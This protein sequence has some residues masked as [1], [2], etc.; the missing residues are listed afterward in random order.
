MAVSPRL[1]RPIGIIFLTIALLNILFV[2]YPFADTVVV[3]RFCPG[4]WIFLIFVGIAIFAL[5]PIIF[6]SAFAVYWLRRKKLKQQASQMM[7]PSA[8]CA[9]DV[10]LK[11][12]GIG[13]GIST[14]ILFSIIALI[15]TILVASYHINGVP[16]RNAAQFGLVYR[17]NV[18]IARDINLVP[19]IQATTLNDVVFAQ[20]LVHCQ[21]RLYQMD[22]LQRLAYGTLSVY[23]GEA[24]VQSDIYFRTLNFNQSAW[25]TWNVLDPN[26]Q[27]ALQAYSDGVNHY[28]GS[29]RPNQRPFEYQM[30][31]GGQPP[32]NFWTPQTSLVILK[33]YQY[34][35][36]ANL[37]SELIRL[38][39]L[40]NQKLNVTRVM[41]LVPMVKYNGPTMWSAEELFVPVPLMGPRIAAELNKFTEGMNKAELLQQEFGVDIQEPSMSVPSS[42]GPPPNSTGGWGFPDLVSLVRKWEPEINWIK[43]GDY[44]LQ[45]M[46]GTATWV[47]SMGADFYKFTSSLLSSS[48]GYPFKIQTPNLMYLNHLKIVAPGGSFEGNGLSF[49]GVPGIFSGRTMLYAWAATPMQADIM[50]LYVLNDTSADGEQYLYNN[51]P[52]NYTIRTEVIEVRYSNPVVVNV[53]DSVHG[54]VISDSWESFTSL[55]ERP[56]PIPGMRLALNWTG[57]QVND[58]TIAFM[59]QSWQQ[60]NFNNFQAMS[61]LIQVPAMNVF[62]ADR[63]GET[64]GG[65]V[66]VGLVPT[67]Q[68]YHTGLIPVSGSSNAYDWLGFQDMTKIAPYLYMGLIVNAG[69]RV[70]PPGFIFDLGYDFEESWRAELLN[71]TVL[72]MYNSALT[73]QTA[74]FTG[75]QAQNTLN[76]LSSGLMYALSNALNNTAAL[77]EAG[78]IT[79]TSGNKA[80]GMIQE[81]LSWD[82]QMTENSG[83]GALMYG[84]YQELVK[85]GQWETK[86]MGWGRPQFI[87]K[88]LA[89][90]G[91]PGTEIDLSEFGYSGIPDNA[92]MER[93]AERCRMTLNLVYGYPEAA[94]NA[95]QYPCDEFIAVSLER[96]SAPSS[97]GSANHITFVHLLMDPTAYACACNRKLSKTGG[98]A[99]SVNPVLP[100]YQQYMDWG[101]TDGQYRIQLSTDGN[102]WDK[103]KY[104]QYLPN[105]SANQYGFFL[106][107]YMTGSGYTAY[108]VITL[109]E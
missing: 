28:V 41:D 74:T 27:A 61:Y 2:I 39:L 53:R 85:L 77:I 21:D 94:V 51:E 60:T 46:F 87:V 3:F 34:V 88:T 14:I 29:L 17:P 70:V 109:D 40:F 106:P 6:Y 25:N 10:I 101:K 82:G 86:L 104:D 55:S 100:A 54:P 80:Y 92:T 36:S 30:H 72:E 89:P 79:L 50:D 95:T 43:A 71:K 73:N 52:M 58:T 12:I 78:N 19:H 35:M 84:W 15:F 108:E 56:N 7:A 69:N 103:K 107:M 1:Y 24:A 63:S 90:M 68:S 4:Y 16:I 67:R 97:L 32:A 99:F 42:S 49:P 38:Y 45:N 9:P 26:T 102:E 93:N 11:K 65:Y 20:G 13:L 18:T 33:L 83:P 37:E 64:S 47:A 62:Y 98:G 48:L 57:F 96:T 31:L 59:L 91:I 44:F 81:L 76:D 22:Y 23:V 66:A 105:F 5:P 75:I 8:P